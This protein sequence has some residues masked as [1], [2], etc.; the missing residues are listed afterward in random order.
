[1]DDSEGSPPALSADIETEVKEMM[2][3]FD[4]P[5]FARRGQDLEITRRRLHERC[6][7]ARLQL[8]DMVQLRL[9]QWSRAVT[10]PE[11]WPAVFTRSIEPLWSLAAAEPPRW[12]EFA[13]PIRRQR[14]IARDLLAAVIRFN[15]RWEQFVKQLNLEPV[16]T[17]IDGYNRYYV[18]E[19]ECVMGSAR[20]AARHFQ[21]VPLVTAARLLDD[22]PLLPVPEL[23]VGDGSHA[24]Q[25]FPIPKIT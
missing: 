13:A 8:L 6:D 11:A 12:A 19:K 9:R 2:G 20:L 21:P 5:A 16:N 1:V 17:V 23:R 22:H 4:L 18:L 24:V 7:K 25:T 15:R 14:T 10:G 3:L